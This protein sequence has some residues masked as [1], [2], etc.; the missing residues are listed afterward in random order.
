MN[1]PPAYQPS[2]P[3]LYDDV[4]YPDLQ[5]PQP[6]KDVIIIQPVQEK[7][8]KKKMKRNPFIHLFCGLTAAL[9]GCL[10]IPFWCGYCAIESLD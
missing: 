4:L 3:P 9:S 2:A 8:K 7:K 5:K 10:T 6:K 1:H